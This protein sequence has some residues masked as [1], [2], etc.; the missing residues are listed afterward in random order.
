[1][2]DRGAPTAAPNRLLSKPRPPRAPLDPDAVLFQRA[3][4]LR[5][6]PVLTFHSGTHLETRPRSVSDPPTNKGNSS[7]VSVGATTGST[8][9]GDGPCRQGRWSRRI[10]APLGE[11]TRVSQQADLGP[12]YPGLTRLL[13]GR[14]SNAARALSARA[15]PAHSAVGPPRV[16]LWPRSRRRSGSRSGLSPVLRP[17]PPIPCFVGTRVNN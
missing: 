8:V 9:D 2:P 4:F 1:M 12:Q 7:L 13:W 10:T 11:G 17:L 16:P 15:Q 3:P 5:T 14:R 6:Q